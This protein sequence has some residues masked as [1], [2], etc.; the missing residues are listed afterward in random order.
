M[1]ARDCII[2]TESEDAEDFAEDSTAC[3]CFPAMKPMD[4]AIPEVIGTINLKWARCRS[5]AGVL[6]WKTVETWV[7]EVLE[8]GHEIASSI[9]LIAGV[10]IANS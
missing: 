9:A 1:V 8:D 2:S 6:K 3:S 5:T 7:C 10:L 4:P